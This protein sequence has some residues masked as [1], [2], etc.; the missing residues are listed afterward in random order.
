VQDGVDLAGSGARE[1]DVTVLVIDDEDP[2]R[3]L[4]RA[5]LEWA[6][7]RVLEAPDGLSGLEVARSELPDLILLDV[8]MGGLNGWE[9]ADRLQDDPRTGATPVIF[10]TALERFAEAV[11]KSGIQGVE[12]LLEPFNPFEVA[13]LVR[14]VLSGG[15]GRLEAGGPRA[16]QRLWS[17]TLRG[18]RQ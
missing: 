14:G 8:L 13:P 1:S 11:E 9:V 5:N 16:L 18:E 4:L 7:I 17:S 10:L 6:G 12:M 15:R 3:L 2:I